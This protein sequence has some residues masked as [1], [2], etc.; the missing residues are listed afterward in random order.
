MSELGLDEGESWTCSR[1]EKK[2]YCPPEGC[3]TWAIVCG[4]TVP[5]GCA[6]EKGWRPGQPSPLEVLGIDPEDTLRQ[7]LEATL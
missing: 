5:Y 2:L 7:V 1:S 3:P 4:A 6:R